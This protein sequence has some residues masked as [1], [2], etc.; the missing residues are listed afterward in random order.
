M[1]ILGTKLKEFRL[2]RKLSQQEVAD[3]LNIKQAT[4]CNWEKGTTAPSAEY[5]PQL[6][7][8]FSTPIQ[9]F[10]SSTSQVVSGTQEG[11]HAVM[12]FNVNLHPEILETLLKQH[13]AQIE[14]YK[15][16]IQALQTTNELLQTT[17]KMQNDVIA[18]LIDTK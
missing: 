13:E 6:S 9:E 11:D 4:Y 12:G 10:F 3:Q 18:K 5:F 16:T 7:E 14:A 1:S 8:I 2:K 17:N 15:S